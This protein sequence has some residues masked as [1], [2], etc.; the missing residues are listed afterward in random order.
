MLLFLK[1]YLIVLALGIGAAL[2]HY[3]WRKRNVRGAWPF[4]WLTLA[5]SEWVLTYGLE[6]IAS[7]LADKLLWAKLQYIGISLTPVAWYALALTYAH[8]ER[9]LSKRTL[10]T[11][12]LM[13]GI[14][15]ALAFTNEW[16]GLIWHQ[17]ILTPNNGFPML[18]L[19]HGAWF[20]IHT[21]FSYVLMALG[22]FHLIVPALRSSGLLRWQANSMVAAALVPWLAN[23]VYIAQMKPFYPF[24][25]TPF[26]FGLSAL[27]FGWSLLRLRLLDLSPIAHHTILRVLDDGVFALDLQQR[28]IHA[29]PAAAAVAG[30]PVRAM[31]GRTLA[32]IFG[33]THPLTLAVLHNSSVRT[34]V[35]WED[36][37]VYRVY[38]MQVL[39]LQQHEQPPAGWLL[40]MHDISERKHKEEIQRV[41]AQISQ[42]FTSTHAIEHALYTAARALV[43]ALADM[44]VVLLLEPNRLIRQLV[45]VVANPATEA[46]VQSIAS[47]YPLSPGKASPYFEALYQGK[48]ILAS[49]LK[50]TD[51]AEFAQDEQHLHM[52]QD[53]GLVSLLQMPLVAHGQVLGACLF[54]TLE[55]RRMYTPADLELLQELANNIA[56]AMTNARL[57]TELHTSEQRYRAVVGQAADSILLTDAYG[58]IIDTNNRTLALLGYTREQLLT[59]R[60]H[61]LLGRFDHMNT[62]GAIA[63]SALNG[64]VLA[65]RHLNNGFVP[66]EASVSSFTEQDEPLFVVI[67]RD[68]SERIAN[69]KQLRRQNDELLALH[70]TTLGLLDRLDLGHLLET[71]VI[72]AGALLDTP[73]GYLY[74]HDAA[75]DMLELKVATGV[76]AQ[77]LGS[78]IERGQGLAGRVWDSGHTITIANYRAWPHRLTAL[79]PL[80]LH[81]IINVPIHT[82]TTFIG[83]LGLAYQEATRRPSDAEVRLLQ[84]FSQLVSLAIDN[85]QLYTAAQ[86]ELAE[87]RR[88]EAALRQAE[89]ELRRA[90]E[91][92]EAAT[93]AKSIFLAHMSH[94]LRTPLTSLAGNTDLLLMTKLDAE[95]YEFANRIRISS[96]AL[97][98]VINDILDLSKIESGK[99]RIE[100]QPFVL[101]DCIEE[102]IDI[103]AAQAAQK[104][105]DLAYTIDAAVP[106]AIVGD[107][108]RLRQV[109]INLLSNAVKFTASGEIGL[110]VEAQLIQAGSYELHF[111]VADTGIGIPPERMQRL[112]TSFDQGDKS[113]TFRYGGTGLGLNISKQL[114]ELMSGQIW[115]ESM[116]NIGSV[117]HVT[118]RAEATETPAAPFL[119][120]AGL[121]L[122]I[123][124]E[125][126]RTRDAIEQQANAWG[127]HIRSTY[128]ALEALRWVRSGERFDIAII[129]WQ[130]ADMSAPL[131]AEQLR[132]HHSEELPIM[133]LA[134]LDLH[135]EKLATIEPFVYEVLRKPLKF[136]QLG[137]VFSSAV[138]SE[139]AIVSKRVADSPTPAS[140]SQGL[141]VLVVDDDH[142][143][144]Q[145]MAQMLQQSGFQT[146]IASSGQQALHM[147]ESDQYN[148]VLLDYNLSDMPGTLLART[149]DSR[150]TPRP[151]LVA[152][153]AYSLDELRTL[154][155][156]APID[157]FLAKPV[158]K[159]MLQSVLAPIYLP[160][161]ETALIWPEQDAGNPID[162]AL[163]DQTA[164]VLG[165]EGAMIMSQ[166]ITRFLDDAVTLVEKLH[167]A[168]AHND[169]TTLHQQAHKLRSGSLLVAAMALAKR[170]EDIE[171]A[172]NAGQPAD[173]VALIQQ[174]EAELVRTTSVL[175][176]YR[177]HVYKPA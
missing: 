29:N 10:A 97:L 165:P 120:L 66:V 158:K 92:A 72:R 175:L 32:E 23:F 118:I 40:I 13:P 127:M 124:E 24:D 144:R 57:F 103:V 176:H 46:L 115:A 54:A 110:H 168:A 28:V 163:L 169:T 14:T 48:P 111:S 67:L 119:S 145:L 148:A 2:S 60:I 35:Q 15:T 162:Y 84:R 160:A 91:T 106:A 25:L 1:E 55:S 81:T 50:A 44:C 142:L 7:T 38:D 177:D 109:M 6:L 80:N 96:N 19:T 41:F 86:Q 128:S 139:Q 150:T 137:L 173:W 26:A 62:K 149:I 76:F 129:D 167:A 74:M 65:A 64:Q 95:Q 52:L 68:I 141:R 172:T 69:E 147:L 93:E 140:N 31:I 88:T 33:A 18:E 16:H 3:A 51:L 107:S 161:A 75:I 157:A 174:V 8:P 39:L 102:V 105:L 47:K 11:L 99:M 90:K 100:S 4:F 135:N 20:S 17:A 171:R 122:L 12:L 159:A 9:Q 87:R 78:R 43:P 70:A 170:C 151:Y 152:L 104:H 166:L 73:H 49:Q 108:V 113:I 143:N 121:R 123:V 131:L 98:A 112:F 36:A 114:V 63:L 154:F 83:V 134:A 61:D 155:G 22:T 164:A 146:H 77:Q 42:Q 156:D 85:A 45:H 136:S 125:F 79:D 153:S 138:A 89:A 34:E 59:H 133:L 53:L 117:F 27:V 126:A 94:E 37:G 82:H 71:I 101:R 116:P 30:Q 5:I 132:L 130:N 21:F 56:L 58:R